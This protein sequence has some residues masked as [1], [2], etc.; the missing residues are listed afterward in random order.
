MQPSRVLTRII[1][2]LAFLLIGGIADAQ[3]VTRPPIQDFTPPIDMAAL[4]EDGISVETYCSPTQLRTGVA[5]VAWTTTPEARRRVRVDVT[6]H[7]RGFEMG[8]Y[9]S[10]SAEGER[11]QDAD[12]DALRESPT[13]EVLQLEP[14]QAAFDEERG[15]A[16]LHLAGLDPGLVYFWCIVDRGDGA[17]VEHTTRAEA[18]TCVADL[19]EDG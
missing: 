13:A 7:K 17:G 8:L 16:E 14:E 1:A 10:F 6:V 3:P 5:R 9:T 2:L 15:I 11:L 18:P 4:D 19:K 12:P